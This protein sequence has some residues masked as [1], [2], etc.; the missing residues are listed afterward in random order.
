MVCSDI[1]NSS[2]TSLM[3]KLCGG[4]TF[5]STACRILE[6]Y[7]KTVTSILYQVT[8]ILTERG[9]GRAIAPSQFVKDKGLIV[10]RSFDAQERLIEHY[11]EPIG[12]DRFSGNYQW[13]PS[14]HFVML[15]AS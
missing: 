6:L 9:E 4:S 7:L 8:S 11:N 13:N 10:N 2:P 5:R 1:P 3:A 14:H 12:Q 15:P